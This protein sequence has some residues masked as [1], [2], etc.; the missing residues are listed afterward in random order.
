MSQITSMK[1]QKIKSLD[2]VTHHFFKTEKDRKR[3]LKRVMRSEQAAGNKEYESWT[4]SKRKKESQELNKKF[5]RLKEWRPNNGKS[6]LFGSEQADETITRP[7]GDANHS[8][9]VEALL[10]PRLP[11]LKV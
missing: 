1:R 10:V 9:L 11:G 4:I 7:R 2:D 6:T 3:A 8:R 5:H